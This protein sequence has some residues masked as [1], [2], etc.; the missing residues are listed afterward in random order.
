MINDWNF[1]L[2]DLNSLP[3]PTY[4]A[5]YYNFISQECSETIWVFG[6]LQLFLNLVN[7]DMADPKD[8]GSQ[9]NFFN[10]SSD[11]L[12]KYKEEDLRKDNYIVR[13]YYEDTERHLLGYA[14][15]GKFAVDYRI[16]PSNSENFAHAFRLAEAYLNLA[17]AAALDDDEETAVEALET[18]L[19]NRFVTGTEIEITERG[20]AL[21]ERIRLERRLELCFEGHRWFDLRRYGMPSITRVWK[22][23]DYVKSYTLK[24]KDPFYTLPIPPSVLEENRQL[25]QNPLPEVRN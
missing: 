12:G 11:L 21:V 9:L 20:D 2:T 14:P 8:R 22:N 10:A 19:K 6:S 15:Y 5:P 18:L 1:T 24:E 4:A 13:R 7:I 16:T 25:V 23:G 3:T 17:E